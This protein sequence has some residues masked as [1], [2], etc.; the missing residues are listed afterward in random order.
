MMVVIGG[1]QGNCDAEDP[2][3]E[4]SY[5][6]SKSVSGGWAELKG[7][8]KVGKLGKSRSGCLVLNARNKLDY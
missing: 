2:D 7:K 8:D 4:E 3:I 5:E 6:Y 1:C